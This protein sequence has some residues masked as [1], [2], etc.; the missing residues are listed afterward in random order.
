MLYSKDSS[1]SVHLLSDSKASVSVFPAP[2][3]SS[4]SGIRLVT[5]N[6]SVMTCIG[7]R[8]IPLL[9]G[10]KSFHWTFQL[11]PVLVSILKLISYA[12]QQL[13]FDVAGGC[14]FEHSNPLPSG[15]SL[16][17]ASESQD[18]PLQA[19]LLSLLK[20]SRI[21]CTSSPL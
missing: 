4:S 20:L 12:H 9:F 5:S 17:T 7:S 10:S 15:E 6:I 16:P 2:A 11:A 18:F 21:Y 19:N 1:P 13:L 3:S 14:L 8:I